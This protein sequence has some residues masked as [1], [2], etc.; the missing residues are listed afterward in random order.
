MIL[1]VI[2]ALLG[3]LAFSPFAFSYVFGFFWLAPLFL[4]F[5]RE[6]R[7]WQ[8]LAG[9][10][11][12]RIL[13]LLGTVYY[14][15]E[16]I[17]WSIALLLF[18]GLPLTIAVAKRYIPAKYILPILPVVWTIFDHIQAQYTPLPT[19]IITAGN[20][21][22][23]SPFVGLVKPGG[24]IALTAFVAIINVIILRIYLSKHN[25]RR[26][27]LIGLA[28]VL[29]TTLLYSQVQLRTS[30]NPAGTAKLAITTVSVDK[31][32]TLS[33]AYL[34]AQELNT[35][36]ADMIVLP[37]G[38]L[39]DLGLTDQIGF[40]RSI[41]KNAR[42]P[43][44]ATTKTRRQ[45]TN[46]ISTI[47][48]DSNGSLIETHNKVR[49][50]F[51]GEYWPFETWRPSF[52][53][54]IAE[55]NPSMKSYTIF[56]PANGYTP[57]ERNMITVATKEGP[58]PIASLICLEVHYPYDLV[59]YKKAGARLIINPTSNRW[60]TIGAAHFQYLSMNL[61]TIESVWMGIPIVTAGVNDR[62]AVTMPNGKTDS[63]LP[64]KGTAYS[65]FTATAT[66]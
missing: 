10:I 52:V 38:M 1:S 57:G 4:F 36:R 23:V 51:M 17:N 34:L 54:W 50:T 5:V 30:R 43:V 28:I 18:S 9:A 27:L 8:L 44:I 26:S 60:V 41:A 61:R 66:L 45:D 12:F 3:I 40:Y 53:D 24:I 65:I 49:L 35:K 58:I 46:Q 32:F 31:N 15:L 63:S 37:E 56:D 59:H 6:R 13:F 25:E 19:T 39:D 7:I 2:S 14:T 29:T 42:T 33:N 21:M 22:G 64:T 48:I 16:P 55:R 20:G 62:A 11:L 47:L